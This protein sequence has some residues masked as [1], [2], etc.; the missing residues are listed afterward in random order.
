MHT[1]LPSKSSLKHRGVSLLEVLVAIGVTAIGLLGVMTLIPLGGA[2]ARQGQIY[3]RSVVVG[4]SAMAE[5]RA[6]QMVYS[7]RW[8]KA[9]GTAPTQLP[10]CIDPRGVAAGLGP[11]FPLNEVNN[12]I[13]RMTR[14]T[15][16]DPNGG[17]MGAAAAE[18]IFTSMD[19]LSVGEPRDRSLPPLQLWSIAGDATD[20]SNF[21]RRQFK[22]SMTWMVTVQ[23]YHFG[24]TILPTTSMHPSL[25]KVHVVVFNNRIV[26]SD[27]TTEYQAEVLEIPGGGV[28]GGDITV[29]FLTALEDQFKVPEN[30]WVMLSGKHVLNQNNPDQ[31]VPVH[32]WYRVLAADPDPA[33]PTKY[34]LTLAGPDWNVPANLTQLTFIRGTVAV[35]TRNMKLETSSLWAN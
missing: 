26:L 3:D 6:R 16:R 28:S 27:A 10:V 15:L 33:L 21:V 18:H 25:F 11:T 4:E 19:D 32:E 35:Y 5:V 8:I 23:G 2:Q 34:Y 7:P 13:P 12:Q 30:E 14:V 24:T 31:W 1:S 17:V 29:N 22:G 20:S 9:D